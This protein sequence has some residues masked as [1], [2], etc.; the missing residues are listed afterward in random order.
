[1]QRGAVGG[2]PLRRQRA[3]AQE[4]KGEVHSV[5]FIATQTG[6]TPGSGRSLV[7]RERLFL[8]R[9]RGVYE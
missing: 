3:V 2:F 1:M 8:F 9:S 4:S 5:V 6:G 7:R